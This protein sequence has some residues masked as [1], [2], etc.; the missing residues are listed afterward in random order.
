MGASEVII[1]GNYCTQTGKKWEKTSRGVMTKQRK[2]TP[3]NQ[4]ENKIERRIQDVKHK[5][6]LVLQF[7][8]LLVLWYH[9]LIFVVDCLNH[10]A[11]KP[12]GYRTSMEVLNGDTTNISP[13]RFKFWQPIK[14]MDKGSFPE[15]RWTMGRF[16]GIYWDTDNLFTFKVWSKPDSKWQN[17]RELNRNFVRYRSESEILEKPE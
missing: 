6:A 12:L 4:N 11:N 16:I 2:F 1:T 15:S 5:T 10:I 9:T 13:F 17:G 8:Y 14:F 3:H 7:F